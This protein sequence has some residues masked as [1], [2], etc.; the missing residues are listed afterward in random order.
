MSEGYELARAF[1]ADRMACYSDRD[2]ASVL[3]VSAGALSYSDVA[4][5]A[6]IRNPSSKALT[7]VRLRITLYD[8]ASDG[9]QTKITAVPKY[10]EQALIT[11]KTPSGVGKVYVDPTDPMSVILEV[12]CVNPGDYKYGTV[13]VSAVMNTKVKA[14]VS[15]KSWTPL[16]TSI[17]NPLAV[18]NLIGL[19]KN[20]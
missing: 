4:V 8:V 6:G 9:T 14:C 19:R 13:F 12:G 1:I 5:S 17:A 18:C 16:D 15:L 3:M 11:N 10:P 20:G 7:E 2:K